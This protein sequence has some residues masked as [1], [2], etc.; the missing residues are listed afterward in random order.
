MLMSQKIAAR[1]HQYTYRALPAS[2]TK[3]VVVVGGSFTGI[4]LAKR[5]ADTL[6]SGYRVVLIGIYPHPKV[7]ASF[8]FFNVNVSWRKECI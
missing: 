8:I 5:L 4:A 3:N 1:I 2:E 6:P 7:F